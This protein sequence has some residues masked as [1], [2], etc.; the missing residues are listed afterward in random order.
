[1]SYLLPGEATLINR[2][3]GDS[4]VAMCKTNPKGCFGG[5]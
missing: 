2:A 1:V 3:L 5:K 4:I